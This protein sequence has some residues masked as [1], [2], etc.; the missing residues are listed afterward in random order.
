MNTR[1]PMDTVTSMAR[2]PEFV[3][4]TDLRSAERLLGELL[5]D[6]GTLTPKDVEN[7]VDEQKRTG[8]RFG[9]AARSLGLVNRGELEQALSR[10]YDY[11]YLPANDRSL[12]SKVAAAYRPTSPVGEA[13]R[14]LRSQLT[15]RWFDGS[16]DR[17]TMAVVGVESGVGRSFI[18]ANLAVVFA[19]LGERTLLIDA[20]LR[21]PTQHLMFRLANKRGLSGILSGRGSVEQIARFSFLPELA[22]LS[23]GPIPPNPQELLAR[24]RF[25]HLL[26]DLVSEYDV[27]LIDTPAAQESADAQTIAHRSKGAVLIARRDH[28]PIEQLSELDAS[29]QQAGVSVMGLVFN[30]Y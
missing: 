24:E 15:M 16:R 17:K 27:I 1:D 11:P 3:E 12:S 7:I 19:Q 9:D 2:S 22:V 30:D 4:V 13:M 14:A 18:A 25:A 21:R 20:N 10:Q 29:L 8:R 26:D 23:A 5:L 28:T 6:A